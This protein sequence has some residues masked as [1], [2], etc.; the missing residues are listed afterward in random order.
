VF[1]YFS[2]EVELEL[3]MVAG[4]GLGTS[5]RVVKVDC[6]SGQAFEFSWPCE[7]VCLVVGV[8]IP[9][10]MPRLPCDSCASSSSAGVD[11]IVCMFEEIRLID[12]RIILSWLYIAPQVLMM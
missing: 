9:G 3:S 8:S 10:A 6:C 2:G 7:L 4:S 12:Y 1:F 11:Q 5:W